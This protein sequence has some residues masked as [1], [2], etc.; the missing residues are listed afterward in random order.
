V[1]PQLAPSGVLGIIGLTEKA[2]PGA[3]SVLSTA[4]FVDAFGRASLYAMPDAALALQ[5]GVRELV[6]VAV[7]PSARKAAT[8]TVSAAMGG[9][10]ISAKAPGIWAN[11]F[12]VTLAKR[13]G[14]ADAAAKDAADKDVVTK[15]AAAKAETKEAADKESTAAAAALVKATAA[16]KSAAAKF[17][18]DINV[19]RG[20]K[21]IESLRGLAVEKIDEQLAAQSE[22]LTATKS[23][24]ATAGEAPET[25]TLT[26]GA[27]ASQ[28]D[29]KKALDY[30]ES[31]PDV[32]MV[33]AAIQDFSTPQT[34]A[35]IYSDVIAHCAR[36]SAKAC[37]RIGFGQVPGFADAIST[38]TQWAQSAPQVFSDRFVLLAPNGV[39]GAVAGMI[40]SLDYYQSPTF[41]AIAG[42]PEP[43][44]KLLAEEQ[45][46]LLK[47]NIV[48]VATMRGRGTVV[49]RGLTTDGDQISVRRVADHAVRGVQLTGELFIGRLNNETGRGA[50]REKL[51]EFLMQM[52]KEGAIVPSTD[53]RDP[54]FKVNV[55]SSQDDFAKGIVRIDM[56]VRPVRA[57]DYIYAT[58]LVQ[59]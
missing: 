28:A 49:V 26:G 47:A 54:A 30:L 3:V 12:T 7:S 14:A 40:G 17:M 25:V 39:A 21:I 1:A 42:V 4:S 56:A 57:I 59:A 29:Y 27:D 18:L 15:T 48:P 2:P 34:V 13:R 53:R 44:R 52:E 31:E 16:A 41:K 11:D 35:A 10:T 33:L 24:D 37:G 22:L 6:V 43:S 45:E 20:G 23:S 8:V 5:N 58:V 36:M 51:V 19:S 46:K 38:P 55:Y 9:F 50:L 32:D